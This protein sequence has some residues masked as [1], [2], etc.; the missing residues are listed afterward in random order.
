MARATRQA[1]FTLLEM[2]VAMT[3]MSFLAGTLYASLH[4]AFSGRRRVEAALEPAERAAAAMHMM[5]SSLEAATAPTGLLAREFMGQGGTGSSGRPADALAF[6]A[7]AQDQ[8]RF[9][10]PSPIHLIEIDL[11][12]DEETG[13][14]VLLRRTTAN[15]L[16][17]ETQDPIEEVVCRRVLSLETT[18][19][20]GSSWQDTWDST[21]M[22]NVLPMAVEVRL[23]LAVPGDED[24]YATTRIF[25][26]PCA[27]LGGGASASGGPGGGT[28]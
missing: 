12:S 3:L 5:Q 18:F 22:G 25:A 4:T 23:V 6:H 24:G 28:R 11:A 7:L 21:A 1:G 16:A 17:P 26:L 9:A 27:A 8:G 10:P 20:D 2:L 15:L 19:Y 13:E 14:L